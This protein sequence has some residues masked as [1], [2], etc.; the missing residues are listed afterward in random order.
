M[1]IALRRDCNAAARPCN[2]HCVGLNEFTS[3]D[4]KRSRDRHLR[5]DVLIHVQRSLQHSDRVAKACSFRK[6][7]RFHLF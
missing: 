6:C 5:F 1:K 4:A 2:R 7:Q 3:H